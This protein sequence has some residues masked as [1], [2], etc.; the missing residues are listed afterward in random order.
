MA[1]I[2]GLTTVIK[3]AA[4]PDENLTIGQL[5]CNYNDYS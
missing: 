2:Q 3:N 5:Y 1:D 4:I